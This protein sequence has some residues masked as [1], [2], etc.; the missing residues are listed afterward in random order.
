MGRQCICAECG[1]PRLHFSNNKCRECYRK[2]YA[3]R[4][5]NKVRN[6]IVDL[7]RENEQLKEE[8]RLLREGPNGR[9]Q[10]DLESPGPRPLPRQSKRAP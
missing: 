2:D 9:A 4:H 7:R 1:Q 3:R 8:I 5:W 6:E 10:D